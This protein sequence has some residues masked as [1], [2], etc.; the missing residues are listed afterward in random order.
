[1][2]SLYAIP[3][4]TS[5]CAEHP[6]LKEGGASHRPIDSA[7]LLRKKQFKE[8]NKLKQQAPKVNPP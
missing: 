7:G 2:Y 5:P 1:M 6:W 3:E 4:L 8:T